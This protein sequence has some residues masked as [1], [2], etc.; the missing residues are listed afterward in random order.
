DALRRRLEGRRDRTHR[1]VRFRALSPE[2]Q[3]LAFKMNDREAL[4]AARA[5]WRHLRDLGGPGCWDPLPKDDLQ[6]PQQPRPRGAAYRQLL[7]M[8]G[9]LTKEG[10]QAGASP[11][12]QASFRSGLAA[13]GAARRLHKEDHSWRIVEHFCREGFGGAAGAKP[14]PPPAPVSEADHYFL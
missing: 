5:A 3:E 6:A 1:L 4:E 9:L 14:L 7:V 12:A 2:S 11:A 8:A 10:L 13:A